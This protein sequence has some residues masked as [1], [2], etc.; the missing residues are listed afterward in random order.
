MKEVEKMF[1]RF[2]VDKRNTII[3]EVQ[4]FVDSANI[5]KEF[6]DSY[7]LPFGIDEALK[8]TKNPDM[9]LADVI[10]LEVNK[11]AGKENPYMG[12]YI[13]NQVRGA[14]DD[15]FGDNYKDTIKSLEQKFV[16]Y[17]TI[18]DGEFTHNIEAIE[19]D[20]NVFIEGKALENYRDVVK[21]SEIL[22]RLFAHR[23]WL[24]QMK[25]LEVL[26]ETY[27]V[28]SSKEEPELFTPRKDIDYSKFG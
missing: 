28:G 5:C 16:K 17:V 14:F 23:P 27:I 11:Y 18:E 2:D 9:M 1:L 13:E 15:V 19:N 25:P 21:V 8:Y 10:A 7:G 4:I 24:E 12:G 3:S 6:A 22:R 20:C 26:F